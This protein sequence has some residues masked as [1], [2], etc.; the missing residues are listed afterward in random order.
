MLVPALLI[1]LPWYARD[2]AIYGWPDFLGLIRHD[3][4][5]VGQMRTGE[6]LAQVGWDAYM[7]R[8]VE[9]TFKSFW[10]VFGWLGVFMDSRVYFVLAL[11]SGVAVAGSFCVLRI[12]YCVGRS[13]GAHDEPV[14]AQSRSIRNTQSA[15][16]LLAISALLTLLT[17]AWYNTQFV[18]HQGRYLFT[19]LIPSGWRLRQAGRRRSRRVAAG[20]SPSRWRCLRRVLA[21]WGVTSRTGLPK[22]PLA[23]TLVFAGGLFVIPGCCGVSSRSWSR[24]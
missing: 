2:I 10:G 8:A 16:R 17:Y 5:V 19:A 11:L 1:A 18:Q 20:S 21:I 3:Q 12:A 9:F 14:S 15:I 24:C 4:I 22:Q 7:Q 13:G 23:L 6:F